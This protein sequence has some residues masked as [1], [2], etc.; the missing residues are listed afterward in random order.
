MTII[1]IDNY[2]HKIKVQ[3]GVAVLGQR[4][5][6]DAVDLPADLFEQGNF[7]ELLD[8]GLEEYTQ[9]FG[10][11]PTEPVTLVIPDKMVT[12]DTITLPTMAKRTMGETFRTEYHNLYKNHDELLSHATVINTNKKTTSYLLTLI[13]KDKVQRFREVLAAKGLKLEK[14]VSSAAAKCEA[15]TDQHARL[16]RDTYLFLD[17]HDSNSQIILYDKG[18]MF[19]FA[20][21]P[22]GIDALPEDRVVDEYFLYEHDIADLA[23]INAREKAKAAK[24]TMMEDENLNADVLVT[25]ESGEGMSKQDLM[26]M[27]QEMHEEELAAQ[28][29]LNAEAEADDP[30]DT[31]EAT[32]EAAAAPVQA[33]PTGKRYVK[34]PRRLP[35]YMQRPVPET[36]TGMVCENFRVFQSRLLNYVRTCKLSD[37]LPDPQYIVMNLPKEYAFLVQMLNAQEDNG[38][39]FKLLCDDGHSNILTDLEMHGATKI[40]NRSRNPLF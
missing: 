21:L 30:D 19:G 38:L 13:R 26:A 22:F 11:L 23:V 15:L 36:A 40:N 7:P 10:P 28:E 14:I 18:R 9:K 17:V 20:A 6:V 27:A 29:Q 16:H 8:K 32:E 24:L 33:T 25:P 3:R 31:E 1:G 34:K 5:Q 4:A 12:M 39:S 35:A 2:A 37:A